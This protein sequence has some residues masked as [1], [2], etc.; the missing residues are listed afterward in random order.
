MVEV[1][2]YDEA[3]DSL[4]KFAVIIAK[5]GG[6]WVFCRHRER[7]T[8]EIPG[9]HREKGEPIMDTARRELYEETGATEYDLE[10]VCVY[11]V[12]G[13]NRGSRRA[14]ST[15]RSAT[16]STSGRIGNISPMQ[17]RNA[18]V[19]LSFNVTN[20]PILA[21]VAL[22]GFPSSSFAS[23]LNPPLTA[24]SSDRRATRRRY[25]LSE[26]ERTD[27]PVPGHVT[28]PVAAR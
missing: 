10:P 17:P 19:A 16:A 1:K 25:A 18:P 14:E 24:R 28:R 21:S 23:L 7:N 12:T 8:L 5:T 26:A 27:V 6:K 3:D 11:S 22:G 2:F 4:L 13:M 20:A 15:A 9:G